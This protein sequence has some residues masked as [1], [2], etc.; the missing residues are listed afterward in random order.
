MKI[1]KFLLWAMIAVGAL[2]IVAVPQ[3]RAILVA[4][5][6]SFGTSTEAKDD[7][8]RNELLAKVADELYAPGK[9]VPKSVTV[10]R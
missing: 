1:V 7:K 8:R 10:E 4:W 2:A 3:F 5:F 9:P 6:K